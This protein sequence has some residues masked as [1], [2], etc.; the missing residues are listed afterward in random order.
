MF[1]IVNVFPWSM[2][3]IGGPHMIGDIFPRKDEPFEYT[4]PTIYFNWFEMFQ[5]N[6]NEKFPLNFISMSLSL[7]LEI[8]W[9]I[10]IVKYETM[11]SI[12][13]N[14]SQNPVRRNELS[15]NIF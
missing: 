10:W 13:W 6:Q 15:S 1:W 4:Q 11:D 12:M 9:L 7:Y 14:E 5:R 8:Y 3:T 2:I